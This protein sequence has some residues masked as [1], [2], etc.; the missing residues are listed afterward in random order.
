[1]SRFQDS[2]VLPPIYFAQSTPSDRFLGQYTTISGQFGGDFKAQN[3]VET[4]GQLTVR[5]SGVL[6]VV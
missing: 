5:V 4:I 6:G 1:M 2:P 3:T